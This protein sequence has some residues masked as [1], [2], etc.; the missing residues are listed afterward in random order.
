MDSKLGFTLHHFNYNIENGIIW[1]KIKY[2]F[3]KVETNIK[4]ISFVKK[5]KKDQKKE[6]ILIESVKW[7]LNY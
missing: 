7:S 6:N 4:D 5:K 1:W 3:L 2:E